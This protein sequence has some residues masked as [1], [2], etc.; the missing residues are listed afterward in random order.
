MAEHATADDDDVER[1]AVAPEAAPW[2]R[3]VLRTPNFVATK[4]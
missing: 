2:E 4:E 3:K 1:A